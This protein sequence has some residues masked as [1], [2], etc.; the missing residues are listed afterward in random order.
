MDF[1][2]ARQDVLDWITT[3]VEQPN[4]SLNGWAPCPFARRARLNSELDIRPGVCDPLTDLTGVEM[5]DFAV[6]IY[7]YDA[8]TMSAADFMQHIDSLN[9]QY[10]TARDMLALGDHP[11]AVELVKGVQMN[12]GRWALVFLQCLSKLDDFAR[13]IAARGYYDGW[14]PDYLQSLFQH[15]QDPRS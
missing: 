10:L 2:R 14:C 1:D 11:D 4:A 8:H 9:Q 15:R 6:I 7:V 5:Q 3:F 12:Q 13:G